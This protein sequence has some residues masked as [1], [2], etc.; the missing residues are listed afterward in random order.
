MGIVGFNFSKLSVDKKA[1]FKQGDQ[2]SSNVTITNIKEEDHRYS[3]EESLAIFDFDFI[4]TY[5]PAG[6][7]NIN[8]KIIYAGIKKEIK[9]M[10]DSWKK[11]KTLSTPALQFVFNMILYRCN[12]RALEFSELVGLPAPFNLPFLRPETE[13][14]KE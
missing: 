12:V 14:K 13:Q 5:G 8:G 1:E 3:K 6:S 10:I 7:I 2:F 9:D 11:D 4:V